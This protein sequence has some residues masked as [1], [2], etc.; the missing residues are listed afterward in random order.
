MQRNVLSSAIMALSVASAVYLVHGQT[1]PSDLP[2]IGDAN[3]AWR[4]ATKS[5][6]ARARDLLARLTLEE[7]ISLVHADGTF[8]TPGLPR[9]GIGKLWM[10]DGPQGVREEI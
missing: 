1:T 2:A 6:D 3:A 9:F 10:S 4:D 5:V 8:S 7:K